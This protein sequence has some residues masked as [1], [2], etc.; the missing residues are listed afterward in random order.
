MHIV[1]EYIDQNGNAVVVG[2]IKNGNTVIMLSEQFINL[3]RNKQR[4]IMYAQARSYYLINLSRDLGP[5]HH[6]TLPTP[7]SVR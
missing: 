1:V 5:S 4:N 3:H 6:S 2:S 7:L